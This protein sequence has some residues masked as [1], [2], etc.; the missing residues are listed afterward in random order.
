MVQA[1]N[2]LAANGSIPALLFYS[3]CTG[4]FGFPQT[5]PMTGIGIVAARNNENRCLFG[6]H[7]LLKDQIVVE[8]YF[9]P[10]DREF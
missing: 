8:I 3:A 5:L 7:V 4:I 6:A 10:N 9:L 1:L 2:P